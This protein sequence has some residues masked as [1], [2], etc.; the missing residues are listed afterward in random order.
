MLSTIRQYPKR[1][2]ADLLMRAGISGNSGVEVVRVQRLVMPAIPI[3]INGNVEG[4]STVETER[5]L[6]LSLSPD[7]HGPTTETLSLKANTPELHE[8]ALARDTTP[9]HFGSVLQYF[10]PG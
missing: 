3:I 7:T 2:L 4:D 8:L 9:L 6:S 1:A 10:L 5:S